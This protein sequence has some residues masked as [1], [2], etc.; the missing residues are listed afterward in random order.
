MSN[1]ARGIS[2][3]LSKSKLS[4]DIENGF[5]PIYEI[6]SDKKA[7]VADLKKAAKA[8]SVV[9]LASDEDR[10]GEAISWHLYETL[11]LAGKNT[12]RIVFHE[13]TKD[14][15]LKAIQNPRDIDMDLVDAPAGPACARPPRGFRTL[16]D[17]GGRRYSPSFRPGVSSRWPCGSW[18]TVKRR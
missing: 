12:K 18:S 1:P 7:I 9:W 5:K 14:A 10:E 15:I 2:G 8:A 6:P 17:T 13:I 16:P 11:G 3:D 4:V